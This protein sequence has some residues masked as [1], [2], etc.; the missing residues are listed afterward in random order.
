MLIPKWEETERVR[1][2]V[3]HMAG[4]TGPKWP[5]LPEKLVQ[6]HEAARERHPSRGRGSRTPANKQRRKRVLV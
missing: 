2:E 3:R 5:R 6:S 1:V 4:G